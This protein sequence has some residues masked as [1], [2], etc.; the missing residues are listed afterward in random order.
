MKSSILNDLYDRFY[1]EGFTYSDVT[2]S[3]WRSYG[4]HKVHRDTNGEFKPEGGGF[5]D[6]RSRSP[7][8][9]LR[10]FGVQRELR[11][12]ARTYACDN[13]LLL[14]GEEVAKAQG[15]YFSFDCLKQV[16]SLSRL[17]S[18]LQSDRE[19]AISGGGANNL[20]RH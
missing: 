16:L 14:V 7:L 6:F 9:F 10:S 11:K 8:H 19:S 3:H 4:W 20:F 17:L 18:V 2:S 15:R 13:N 12:L 5:G 1:S